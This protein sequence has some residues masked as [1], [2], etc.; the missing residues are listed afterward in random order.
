MITVIGLAAAF[1]TTLAFVPQVIHILKTRRT[2]GISLG[3]YSAF[4]SGVFLWLLYGLLAKDLPILLAN[5]VTFA[6]AA[7]VLILTIQS[8]RPA[9][10]V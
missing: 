3:M 4:T 2:D 7:S 1:L 9:P 8:R 10:A 6:L 5:G